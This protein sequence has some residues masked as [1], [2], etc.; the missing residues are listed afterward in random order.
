MLL[1]DSPAV[2]RAERLDDRRVSELAR[3]ARA[4]DLYWTRHARL[5]AS[6][7]ELNSEPG[8]TISPSDPTT[9]VPYEYRPFEEGRFEVC[10]TFERPSPADQPGEGLW[11]HGGGRQCFRHITRKIDSGTAERGDT[12]G[13]P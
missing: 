4:V 11:S 10:G 1:L 6:L 12:Y 3:V 13:R 5:P 9:N 2:E 8:V 7:S